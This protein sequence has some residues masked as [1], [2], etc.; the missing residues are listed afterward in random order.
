M[1]G[2]LRKKNIFKESQ[3]G[4]PLLSVV[5]VVLN[6]EK[7]LAQ[8]MESVLKQDYQNVEYIV[9]DG[10][11]KDNTVE[12]IRK[13]EDKID[14][15][16]SEKD[17]GIFEA[18]NK[19]IR[20][21]KGEMIGILNSDDF[22]CENV[23]SSIVNAFDSTGADV[24]Y[25]NMRIE[26]KDG[27][28]KPD[29][30]LMDK[31]PSVFHPACFVRKSAYD[32]IGLYD[33]TFKISSD[34]EFLLRCIRNNMQFY[35][36]DKDITTFRPGGMSSKCASNIEGYHIMKRHKTGHHKEVIWRGIKCYAKNFIKKILNLG[37]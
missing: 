3:T 31:K 13:F 11:S 33:E 27:S 35:C 8:A 16:T 36:L 18:M 12:I 19:G 26:G 21:C 28:E 20:L 15:W 6:G 29:I 17:K 4:K 2:G 1:E 5:T 37:R 7:F 32:K 34:Y 14:V 24:V 10:G 30:S 22:Y 9:I 25:G 23:F